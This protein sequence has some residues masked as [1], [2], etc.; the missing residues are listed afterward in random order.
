MLGKNPLPHQFNRDTASVV[1]SID[2]TWS[3][4][5]ASHPLACVIKAAYEQELH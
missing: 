3:Y 1:K 4:S 2:A 5:S